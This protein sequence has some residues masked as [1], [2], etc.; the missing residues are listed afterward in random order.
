MYQV[1][2]DFANVFV[3][4]TTVSPFL[5]HITRTLNFFK[6]TIKLKTTLIKSF[7]LWTELYSPLQSQNPYVDA[8]APNVIV[9]GDGI[10]GRQS[11]LDEVMRV[12]SSSWD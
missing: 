5:V 3:G 1:N 12:G 4:P 11:G 10:L 9:F 2:L 7:L 6:I 8:P